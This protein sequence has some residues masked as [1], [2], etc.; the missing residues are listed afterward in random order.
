MKDFTCKVTVRIGDRVEGKYQEIPCGFRCSTDSAGKDNAR[1]T[2]LTEHNPS[3]AQW[4]AAYN[5]I[6]QGRERAKKQGTA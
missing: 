5:L 3:P 4:T 6:Q 2:H 1:I